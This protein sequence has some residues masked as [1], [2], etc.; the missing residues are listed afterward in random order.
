M[1]LSSPDAGKAGFVTSPQL[2]TL[3]TPGGL[4]VQLMD[5]GATLLSIRVPLKDG[6]RRESLL[7]LPTPEDYGRQV[8]YLNATVG[9]YANRIAGSAFES[10]GTRYELNSG[11]K[12]CLHGGVEGFDKRRFS[13]ISKSPEAVTLPLIS[14]DGDMGFPGNFE[15]TVT[16]RVSDPLTLTATDLGKCDARCPACITSHA[17][18]NLNGVT[19]SILR[20]KL[21][22]NAQQ[23]MPCDDLSIPTGE[24]KE[25]KGTA[26]DFTSEKEIGRDFLQDEQMT[27]CRGYDHPFVIEGT[28]NTP[29]A[30]VSSDDGKLTLKVSSDY[31]AVQFYSGNYLHALGNNLISGLDGQIIQNQGG[32]CL[33]PE[34]YPDAPH[35]PQH[36]QRNP[37][38]SPL[39]PLKRSI[40]WQFEV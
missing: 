17:Y 38:V 12:H 25:V 16:Y 40:V 39:A 33:E 8:C 22:L 7:T 11:A 34:F 10:G 32:F 35:Q 36:A 24:L 3:G 30:H 28:L 4:Q 26:F 13:I 1:S 2:V 19:S 18:F 9:R 37:A 23:F 29:F 21:T 27:A 6:T 15:L 14:P 5:I 20:H 31:P